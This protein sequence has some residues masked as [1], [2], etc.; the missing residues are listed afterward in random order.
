[1]C[2]GMAQVSTDKANARPPQV[3]FGGFLM[4]GAGL[5]L[6]WACFSRVSQLHTISSREEVERELKLQDWDRFLDVQSALTVIQ[7]AATITAACAIGI[8]LLGIYVLRSDRKSRLAATLLLLPMFLP[9]LLIDPLMT[10]LITMGV[11]FLWLTPAR[12]W[13][14]QARERDRQRAHHG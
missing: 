13:F 11:V 12:A 3:G 8:A 9:A 5:G 10:G 7:W 14:D 4:I 2:D 6:V 1:M